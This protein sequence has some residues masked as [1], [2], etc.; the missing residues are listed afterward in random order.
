[1]W[2]RQL[3]LIEQCLKL[4]A[5]YC[6]TIVWLIRISRATAGFTNFTTKTYFHVT[7]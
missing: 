5:P 6:P 4:G 2:G 7:Y 1:M 3:C